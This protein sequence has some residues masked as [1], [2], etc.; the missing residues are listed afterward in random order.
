MRVSHSVVALAEAVSI[1]ADA[2]ESTCAV[3]AARSI[4]VSLLQDC[5]ISREATIAK[6]MIIFFI[7]ILF[8]FKNKLIFLL[9]S[10]IN[11]SNKILRQNE[12]WLILHRIV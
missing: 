5:I 7:F 8:I 3:I 1:F 4:D 2:K 9:N 6:A 10:K 11:I 12:G